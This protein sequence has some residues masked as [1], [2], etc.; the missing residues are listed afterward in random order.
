MESYA[1]VRDIFAKNLAT[2]LAS[3]LTK[4]AGLAA[5]LFV[6]IYS[7]IT[8][9]LQTLAQEVSTLKPGEA[10]TDIKLRRKTVRHDELDTLVD[11]INRFRNERADAEQ[12]LQLD[13]DERKRV[14]AALHKSEDDLS[15]ALRIAQLAYW[16]Y[17]LATKEFILN[18][19]YYSLH[20]ISGEHV[21]GYRMQ[22]D[23]F[24]RKLV[25]PEDAPTFAA[26]IHQALQAMWALARSKSGFSVLTALR[27][28]CCCA[29]RRSMAGEAK[30]SS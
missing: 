21:G 9:H 15:E 17:D 4:I 19:Q 5:L 11:S 7:L 13:I 8:R 10:I 18:D 12:A 3:E 27:V 1:G 20:R 14:E 23:D 6:I 25:H 30:P 29:A 22:A 28:G 26:Y 16:E 24:L 2:E